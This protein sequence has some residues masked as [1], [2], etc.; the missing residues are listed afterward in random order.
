MT[1]SSGA[2]NAKKRPRVVAAKGAARL[3]FGLARMVNGPTV[4]QPKNRVNSALHAGR[5][6]YRIGIID[7]YA[8]V[9]RCATATG[10]A[11]VETARPEARAALILWSG[12]A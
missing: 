2:G 8:S 7:E 6:L 4:A 11:G 1:L 3:Q 5:A 10:G 9:F 12:H